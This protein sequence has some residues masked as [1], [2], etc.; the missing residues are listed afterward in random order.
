MSR[1]LNVEIFTM[2]KDFLS[3]SKVAVLV[4]PFILSNYEKKREKKTFEKLGSTST[5]LLSHRMQ[6]VLSALSG[7]WVAWVIQ[8]ILFLNSVLRPLP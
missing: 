2:K 8:V 6:T 5:L 4:V 1:F 3:D 7:E